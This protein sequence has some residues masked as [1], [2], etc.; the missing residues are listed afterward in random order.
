MEFQKV[1]RNHCFLHYN[2]LKMQD[3][4]IRRFKKKE[5]K[6]KM[7][8]KEMAD[9]M[10]KMKSEIE[11]L[12]TKLV[13]RDKELSTKV[14][15]QQQYEEQLELIPDLQAEHDNVTQKLREQTVTIDEMKYQQHQQREEFKSLTQKLQE[16]ESALEAE[17]QQKDIQLEVHFCLLDNNLQQ[18]KSIASLNAYLRAAKIER[19]VRTVEAMDIDKDNRYVET[20]FYL[21]NCNTYYRFSYLLFTTKINSN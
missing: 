14:S 21:F 5:D 13:E 1:A 9:E 2:K 20:E 17:R 7:V 4:L 10:N 11:T 15:T 16:A 3:S 12:Q 19:E 18:L 6:R 8:F